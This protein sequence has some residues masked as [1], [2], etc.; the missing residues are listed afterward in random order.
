M[1]TTVLSVVDTQAIYLLFFL[2]EV[3]WQGKFTHLEVW[4]S[5]SGEGGPYELLTA[6]GWAPARLPVTGGD[7]SAATGGYVNIVG[8]TLTLLI[9]ET[10]SL[11]YVF[12]GTN[13]I[14]RA[15]CAAQINAAMPLYVS[16]HVDESG[17]FVLETVQAGAVASLRVVNTDAAATLGLP[18]Q[19]PDNLQFG[20]DARI[21]FQTGVSHYTFRDPFG[22][23][24]YFYKTRMYNASTQ[25]A[26]TYSMALSG[27]VRTA[28]DPA[29]VVIG[30]VKLMGLDGR[31]MK[32]REVLLYNSY[33]S[34]QIDDYTIVNEGQRKLSDSDG[35]V[36]YALV[37]GTTVDVVIV[38]TALSRRVTVPSSPSV[39]KFNLLDPAYGN[40][41]A[42]A[43][44]RVDFNY[45]ERRSL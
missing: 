44:Q 21:P 36:E 16:A 1:S 43:V 18:T 13:P 33:T 17:V 31:S 15:D 5:A 3:D 20:Q 7:A 11:S 12:T 38:G 10:L 4:R 28:V 29:Q 35:Y 42:F 8:Q 2:S 26:S 24:S 9:N 30:Y 19:D 41:D 23:T 22:K 34:S 39:T 14:T 40:D 27:A 25:E 45:A 37:R 32:D 6:D